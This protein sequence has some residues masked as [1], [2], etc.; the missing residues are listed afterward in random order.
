MAVKISRK[1]RVTP[2]MFNDA[3]KV[4]QVEAGMATVGQAKLLT[5]VRTGRLYNA[6]NFRKIKNGYEVY[7]PVEYAVFV[8]YKKPFYRPSIDILRKDI[9]ARLY[10]LIFKAAAKY[11]KS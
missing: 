2:E 5:P 3:V 11:A 10:K 9:K 4:W 7:N 6:H 1:G 8:E